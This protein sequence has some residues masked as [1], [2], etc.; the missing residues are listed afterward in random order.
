MT[1]PP[2]DIWALGIADAVALRG[3]CTR[4]QVGAVLLDKKHRVVMTG[5][6]GTVPGKVGCLGGFCRRGRLTYDQIPAGSDYGNCISLHAE[7]NLL[8]HS[9]REDLASGTVYVTRAPCYRCLPRL[10]AAGVH[11]V[12]WRTETGTEA[13]I[14]GWDE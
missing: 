10:E 8:I 1:R 9:R 5:Y 6:N 12:V 11:R 14:L 13:K 4:S 7:E 3:D 2:W